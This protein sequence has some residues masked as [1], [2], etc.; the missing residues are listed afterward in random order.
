MAKKGVQAHFFTEL[1]Q[2]GKKFYPKIQKSIDIWPQKNKVENGIFSWIE[3][4]FPKKL[5]PTPLSITSHVYKNLVKTTAAGLKRVFSDGQHAEQVLEKLLSSDKRLGS[6]DRKFIAETYYDMVRYWRQL[7]ILEDK[8]PKPGTGEDYFLKVCL[9]LIFKGYSLAEWPEL[10]GWPFEEIQKPLD[11]PAILLASYPDSLWKLGLSEIGPK[12]EAEAIALNESAPIYLRA[13]RLKTTPEGVK[14]ALA[15]EGVACHLLPH[16]PDG[17]K[18]EGRTN[19]IR[20]GSFRKGLYEVQD[21]AS[22]TIAPF[23]GAE[24]GHLVID[25][26]AGAGGKTLHLAA[27]MQDA[28]KIVA[29]DVEGWKLEELKKR[30]SRAGVRSVQTEFIRGNKT[31]KFWGEKADRVLLD[32]PCSG[33][34][35]LRRHPDSKW[36]F[37]PAAFEEIIEIQADILDRYSQMVK[38]GGKLV[39]ATCSLM[40]SEN[41]KQVE[42]FLEEH[43][44]FELEEQNRTWPSEGWDG[45][46]MAR[47]FRK[48]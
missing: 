30:A 43:P 33:L 9:W 44:E 10:S 12:W 29:M 3:K 41:E 18:L 14:M 48:N 32:A 19:V 15:G 39:Y 46:F 5:T 11:G 21:A 45:F 35:V 36:K 8:L 1:F 27:L 40:P 4:I 20:L 37:D 22:Q 25:A 23:L 17:L 26:C 47:F 42:H 34:G 38:P 28:G 13:N 16:H 24:P 6:R 7:E 31:I 2:G